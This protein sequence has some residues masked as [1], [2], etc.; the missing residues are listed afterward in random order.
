MIEEVPYDESLRFLFFGEEAS[1]SARL[2]TSGWDF[3]TPGESIIYHLWTRSY[4]RVFQEMEDQETAAWRTASQR[5]VK[6]LL[7]DG[8]H[9]ENESSSSSGEGSDLA[10]G[11]YS[12]GKAR[13]LE[14]YQ[15]HIGVHFAKQQIE[16]AA[17]WGKLDPIR[18]ELSTKSAGVLA[19][20]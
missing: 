1:M 6:K 19:P 7:V 12:L 11:K 5:Y 3:F 18:F 4:R 14:A 10:A 20:M 9:K 15:S 2:W 13:S 16:W 8:T 17:E